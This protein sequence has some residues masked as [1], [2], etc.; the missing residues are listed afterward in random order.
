[1]PTPSFHGRIDVANDCSL[2]PSQLARPPSG[3]VPH[4]R[5]RRCPLERRAGV[6][7]TGRQYP[8]D[9]DVTISS[10]GRSLE[11]PHPEVRFPAGIIEIDGEDLAR[12]PLGAYRAQ[13][14]DR[15]VERAANASRPTVHV[16]VLDAGGGRE[17]ELPVV[18]MSPF[19]WWTQGGILL[20]V[21]A[22]YAIAALVAMWASPGG[23]LARAFSKLAFFV[24]LLMLSIF[25]LS[26]DTAAGA[27]H[28]PRLPDGAPLHG[29]LLPKAA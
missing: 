22:L 2:H 26:H 27:V 11:D 21:G 25:R 20:F 28:V 23:T 14:F 24:A 15:A 1:M 9:P 19:V 5:G 4:V 8:G 7:A 13:A 17:L 3:S 10:A 6:W 29:R 18:R 16:K 12:P